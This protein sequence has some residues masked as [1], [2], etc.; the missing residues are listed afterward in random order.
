MKL[1]NAFLFFLFF[2]SILLIS[3]RNHSHTYSNMWSYD[4]VKH[5][6]VATCEHTNEKTE[7]ADHTWD[8]PLILKEAT[9]E[10]AGEKKLV[11]SVCKA[12]K[13]ETIPALIHLHTYREDWNNDEVY[14]WHQ[15]TCIH[16]DEVSNKEQHKWKLDS[17][18][19]IEFCSVC[20]RV[21]T[22][23]IFLVSYVDYDGTI[24]LIDEFEANT[25]LV[26]LEDKPQRTN[27]RFDGWVYNGKI[28]TNN[29][30]IYVTNDIT[31]EARYIRQYKIDFVDFDGE[32]I[33]DSIYVDEGGEFFYPTHPNREGYNPNGWSHSNVNVTSDLVVQ[34]LY[35][36]KYFDVRFFMPDGTQLGETQRVPWNHYAVAPELNPYFFTWNKNVQ[37]YENNTAY[38]NPK[39]NCEFDSVTQELN[40]Y[41]VYETKLEG[42]VLICDTATISKDSISSGNTVSISSYIFSN[43]KTVYGLDISIDLVVYDENGNKTNNIYFDDE[44]GKSGE[45]VNISKYNGYSQS[46]ESIDESIDVDSDKI[47]NFVWSSGRGNKISNYNAV[48]SITFSLVPN[49]P[50]GTYY[51]DI[52]MDSYLIVD[53]M[54][55]CEPI[56]IS[57]QII[58]V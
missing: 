9:E 21:N 43:D 46:L 30:R 54:K 47:L 57:G 51:F 15:A 38:T 25:R 49:T 1:K 40:I 34:A 56:I 11:C 27:Y 29:D 17:S 8:N 39:W 52:Q 22:E 10:E 18:R 14:H 5:W 28:V 48:F 33:K 32:T 7:E 44:L 58:V 20:Q 19:G 53:G 36:I 55:K 23:Q 41:A 42:V 45:Y 35:E 12:E 6:H 4:E 50:K 37:A 24:I 2:T 3:C 26:L 16:T 13:I 31:I